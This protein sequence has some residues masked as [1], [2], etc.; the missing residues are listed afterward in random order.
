MIR[1][2]GCVS[3]LTI[4]L[5]FEVCLSTQSTFCKNWV[6]SD[7]SCRNPRR[8][9]PML[10]HFTVYMLQYTSICYVNIY[11]IQK[12]SLSSKQKKRNM[13]SSILDLERW[14][15]PFCLSYLNDST[16]MRLLM[17]G[18]IRLDQP[19]YI[20]CVCSLHKIRCDRM[21]LGSQS[22]R[23]VFKS[24]WERLVDVWSRPVHVSNTQV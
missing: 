8:G 16:L 22:L 13:G 3:R 14:V 18:L 11:L 2:P 6:Q 5:L 15:I 10:K 23:L 4:I 1:H 19:F 12:M 20:L 17:V 7:R 9:F 21:C 24:R